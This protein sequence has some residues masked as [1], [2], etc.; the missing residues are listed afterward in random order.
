MTTDRLTAE[1][2]PA[3]EPLAP[4][5][6]AQASVPQSPLVHPAGTHSPLVHPP[7]ADSPLVRPSGPQPRFV[8]PAYFHPTDHPDAWRTLADLGE[9]LAF[10]IVNPDS[11]PGADVDNR[12]F[13]PIAAIRAAGGDLVGYVDTGYGRRPA[14]AVLRD[15]AAYQTWYGL[16]GGFLDQVP[17]GRE[18]V[19]HYRRLI[20][21][22]RQMG[23]DLIA[24]NPGVTPAPEYAESADMVIT[25][26]GPWSAYGDHAAADWT[27]A[28]PPERFCHLVHT[29]PPAELASVLDGARERHAGAVY[30]TELTGANPWGSLSALFEHVAATR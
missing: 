16:R 6:A 25:F 26:E 10:A 22:A 28:Y 21:A 5:S 17:V 4:Q 23:M 30:A 14:S 24:L 15:L 1:R 9:Q 7:G 11:G 3:A 27:S 18:H 8:V 29:T 20:A 19:A 13:E 12:Y 2:P